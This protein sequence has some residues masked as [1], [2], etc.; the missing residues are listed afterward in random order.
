VK[1]GQ[2]ISLLQDILGESKETNYQTEWGGL[3]KSDA[4]PAIFILE[5]R[6]VPQ[7]SFFPLHVLKRTSE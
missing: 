4:I 5:T 1:Q 2:D 3:K 6:L 7:T